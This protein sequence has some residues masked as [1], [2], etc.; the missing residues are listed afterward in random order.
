MKYFDFDIETPFGRAIR[1]SVDDEKLPNAFFGPRHKWLTKQA[2]VQMKDTTRVVG[3]SAIDC[4]CWTMDFE[5]IL[6]TTVIFSNITFIETA[7]FDGNWRVTILLHFALPHSAA[8]GLIGQDLA[9]LVELSE[10]FAFLS[11]M[12]IEDI[13]TQDG[14]VS[15]YLKDNW[16][17]MNTKTRSA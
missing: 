16:H 9:K 15:V 8:P 1:V 7:N 10:P 14:G 4:K 5:T 11:S 3:S 6:L 12:Q 13:R 17:H 2:E